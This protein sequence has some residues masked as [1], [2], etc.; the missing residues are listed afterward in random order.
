MMKSAGKS[1]WDSYL[2]PGLWRRRIEL[3][4][5]ALWVPGGLQTDQH[6]R[7]NILSRNRLPPAQ[8]PLL[9]R[10]LL[11][12]VALLDQNRRRHQSYQ[13]SSKLQTLL[14]LP[15]GIRSN[16]LLAQNHLR[17][18]PV[19]AALP[20]PST[21]TSHQLAL[22]S[23]SETL[24]GRTPLLPLLELDQTPPPKHSDHL[25]LPLPL[26]LI[27]QTNPIHPLSTI[28][29]G[30]GP[31]SQDSDNTS[32][33]TELLLR[34]MFLLISKLPTTTP[35]ICDMPIQTR[36]SSQPVEE[37]LQ[38]VCLSNARWPL[39]E[40]NTSTSPRSTVTIP[41][42]LQLIDLP[43]RRMVQSL[44]KQSQ[45]RRK[46]PLF[47]FGSTSSKSTRNGYAD[48]T[49]T[50]NLITTS[51]RTGCEPNIVTSRRTSKLISLSTP[52]FVPTSPPIPILT[53]SRSSL[54]R[55]PSSSASSISKT[56]HPPPTPPLLPLQTENVLSLST[57]SPVKSAIG[58]TTTTVQVDSHVE[59]DPIDAR[60][61]VGSILGKIAQAIVLLLLSVGLGAK[62]TSLDCSLTGGFQGVQEIQE[63][64]E[65]VDVEDQHPPDDLP[66]LT[67]S[68]IHSP[69]TLL[70]S[71]ITHA[72][73]HIP[74]PLTSLRQISLPITFSSNSLLQLDFS[75]IP[76]SSLSLC[77][78]RTLS[79]STS[80]LITIL[81]YVDDLSITVSTSLTD[82]PSL[83]DSSSPFDSSVT[84][85]SSINPTSTSPF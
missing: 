22:T 48:G 79:T 65:A 20:L 44:L 76:L 45:T 7:T 72:F 71:D 34:P 75:A 67:I 53:L 69:T 63:L 16:R 10:P 23:S 43:T 18:K 52:S 4:L 47:Q 36:L 56:L 85:S 15:Q 38:S 64:Q 14:L 84:E 28:A 70:G 24:N 37:P 12:P 31:S 26:P 61:V 39:C 57:I 42:S 58:S 73:R 83:A 46:S 11:D 40:T 77:I 35:R 80:P 27:T 51:T 21:T 1:T 32:P 50:S 41:R 9:G 54:F 60:T 59:D 66:L 29:R 13:L 49:Q 81:T 68:P 3:V 6:R 5:S 74:L 55:L 8:E 62:H 17:N 33:N 30:G 19:P 78:L 25:N 82:S 2:S